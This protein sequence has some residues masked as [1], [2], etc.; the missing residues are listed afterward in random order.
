MATPAPL[1]ILQPQDLVLTIFGSYI[2]RGEAVWSGGMVKILE[3]FAFT[4]GAARAALSRLVNRDLLART[5]HGRLAFYSATPRAEALFANGDRRIFSFGRTEPAISQWT[6]LWHAIPEAERVAR[7]RFAGQLRF[8]GFGSVQDAT[9]VAA[10]DRGPEVSELLRE[11]DLERYASVIVGRMSVEVPPVALIAEAWRLDEAAGRYEAFLAEFGPL[12]FARER[13]QL[14][15]A[16]A[17][18][19]RT[20]LIHRFRGFP[21][22]DP[23]LPAAVDPLETL[24]RRVTGCFDEVYEALEGPAR[25][26]LWDALVVDRRA[27]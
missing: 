14:T 13:R 25:G 27:V 2:R 9:W 22:I 26:Y 8:L 23:E 10:H 6:V 12:R 1:D 19:Q 15:A 5:R 4:S 3:G 16:G 7:S 18:Q 17:F 20:L 21:S 11:L 24:R